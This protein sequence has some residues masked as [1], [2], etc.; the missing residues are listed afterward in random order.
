MGKNS[1]NFR[2]FPWDSV[3]PP[4]EDCATAIGNMHKKGKDSKSG[5]EDM[6]ADIQTHRYANYN[7]LPS[8]L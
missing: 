8:L 3:T 5:S 2:P 6:L 4:E 7:T 1:Q